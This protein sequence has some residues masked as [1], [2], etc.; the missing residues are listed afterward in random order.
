MEKVWKKKV[1]SHTD[2]NQRRIVN[3]RN[4]GA[5]DVDT[6]TSY[7]KEAISE[8][9]F[10]SLHSQPN[11]AK[12]HWNLAQKRK[13]KNCYPFL[14]GIH[15]CKV[16][17]GNHRNSCELHKKSSWQLF[18]PS[19]LPL[20]AEGSCHPP[21]GVAKQVS[22]CVGC[23]KCANVCK[24]ALPRCPDPRDPNSFMKW[25]KCSKL[26]HVYLK[27][28]LI[29]SMQRCSWKETLFILFSCLERNYH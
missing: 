23:V 5:Q 13:L 18:G 25:E 24:H 26:W 12:K 11:T 21:C 22:W 16:C 29:R 9:V 4:W 17:L 28:K 14:H 19:H 8:L 27:T 20:V 2:T 3:A 6:V 7:N 1:M 15:C 10:D